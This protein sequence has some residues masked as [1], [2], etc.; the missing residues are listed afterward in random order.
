MTQKL[1][2][3]FGFTKKAYFVCGIYKPSN[4]NNDF[5]EK[6]MAKKSVLKN[7]GKGTGHREVR[8][9]WNNNQRIN[10]QNKFVPSAVLTRSRRVPVS[11]AKQSSLRAAASTIP[12]NRISKEKINTV[13]ANGV[14]TVKQTTVSAVEG[15]GVTAVKPSSCGN[16]QQALKYKGIFDSGCS[17]HM[18]GN[19]DFL[20]DYQDIDGGF[21]AF[22]GST[23]GG[24]ITGKGKI[25]T[26]KLDFEDVFFVKELKFNLFSV[27]QMCD[28]KNSVLFTET[29]CLVLSPD[30][31]LLD[32]SQV[33]LRVPRQSNM[34]SFDLK[35]VVP[36]GDLTCLFAKATIDES[37]L[38]HRRKRLEFPWRKGCELFLAQVT[39]QESKEKRLEDVPVIQ[40]FLEV[41]PDKLPGLSPPRQ[42]EFRIDLIPGAA[43]VARA[44]YH[45]APS[46]M[47]ELSKKLQELSEKGF[48]RPSS[49]PCEAPID[50]RSGY[51]QL[52]IREEDILITAFRTRYGHYEFQVMPFG[53]TN[54]PAVF[55]DLMNCVCKPYLD[56]FVIVFIDDILIYSKNKEEHGEH[57]KTILNLLRS[58]TLYAKFSKCDFWLDSVQFLS[59][60][61]DS[62]RV[63]VDP[64]KIEA[65]KNWA[66]L[67][68]PTEVRQ[69][70]GLAGYYQRFI[71]E[72]SLISKPLTKLTQKNKPYVWG[73][74]E[75]EAFHTLKLKLCSAPILSLPEGSEDFVVYCD[76]SLKGFGAV[77]MQ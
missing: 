6:K 54:A 27:S 3:G 16:P 75:E 53:L 64:A 62:S 7:M 56:K 70:L 8:P 58:E 43:P 67:T 37:K 40:D 17:R 11:A 50:L 59:H 41:F 20:T 38:W 21:V 25:R 61:I 55:I 33:L 28:K 36:S 68:I 2:L 60:V 42:V 4:K 65:I 15:N 74:D 69:F 5:H 39:E 10:H 18:T 44:P 13:R 34:Y 45:L 71:K 30:F 66:A 49:S 52:R 51:H 24:K 35:N 19:K 47:K 22:G 29:E 14:N 12:N 72:F 9:V 46:K 31:K 73:D 32:E 77:L 63:H 76:A 48:I 23:R 1:G 57:L 26:D